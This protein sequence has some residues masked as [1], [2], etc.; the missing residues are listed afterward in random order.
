VPLAFSRQLQVIMA[1]AAR[2]RERVTVIEGNSYAMKVPVQTA[3]TVA[4]VHAEAGDM[5][6]GV[7]EPTYGSVTPEAVKLGALVKFS[8]ELLDDSP[9]QLM[10]I[11]TQDIGEAIGTLEDLSILDGTN[12]TD[13]L[14]ADLGTGTAWT[15]ASVTLATLAVN[16]YELASVYRSRATWLI[17]EA[18]AEVLTKIT[19]TDGR[20]LFSE[21]NALP[22]PMDDI[23]GGVGTLLGRPCLV[24][25]TGATG[26]TADEAIFGDLS[27]YTL[28]VRDAFRAE[29]SRQSD[30]DTDQSALRVSRREDG[31]LSQAARMLRFA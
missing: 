18:A 4:A 5:A 22:R 29:S 25:P 24:F 26:I 23:E 28:Y 31:I 8:N 14:L 13:S 16:Y 11:V 10:T 3:K 19:A 2:L 17:N 21:F 6:T 30:F 20:P 1:R 27:G 9:L 15:D 12:F 7:T